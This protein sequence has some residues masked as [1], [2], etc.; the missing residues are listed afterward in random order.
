[1]DMDGTLMEFTNFTFLGRPTS[2][3]LDYLDFRFRS[4]P[5]IL[6]T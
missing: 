3:C 2:L 6:V 4:C 1:M 5:C